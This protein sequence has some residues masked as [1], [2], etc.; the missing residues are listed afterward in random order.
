MKEND[1]LSESQ[2]Q[3]IVQKLT[4]KVPDLKC[5]ICGNQHFTIVDGYFTFTIQKDLQNIQLGGT[6]I[7]TIAII[8]N[9]CGFVSS[10]ALGVLGLLSKK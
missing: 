2:R 4:S 10:H 1:V 8:C 5:P 6:T 7:P 3:E 9:N